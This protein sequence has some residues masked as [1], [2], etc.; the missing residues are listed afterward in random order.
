M[1]S[2]LIH[3]QQVILTADE[4]SSRSKPKTKL[5]AMSI[6]PAVD[7]THHDHSHDQRHIQ[8]HQVDI[9]EDDDEYSSKSLLGGSQ[10]AKFLLAGG[11]AG[12]V[13]RSATAPFDRLKVYLITSTKSSPKNL[14]TFHIL[15]NAVHTIASQGGGIRAFWVGNGLNIIKIFPV[16]LID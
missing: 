3:I 8:T 10:A 16:C 5:T 11:I 6:Q 9:D 13:S 7:H 4:S 12:A 14:S 15:Y 1:K 2:I